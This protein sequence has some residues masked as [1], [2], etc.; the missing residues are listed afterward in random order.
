MKTV[1][2]DTST[3]AHL[4]ANQQ[5]SSA[6][7]SSDNFY[8]SDSTIWSY[9]THFPIAKHVINELGEYAVLFTTR[10]YSNTT[11]KHI[12]V[13]RQAC[14]HKNIIYCNNPENGHQS[15]I[16]DFIYRIELFASSLVGAR[17]PEIHIEKVNQV[18]EEAKSYLK[19]FQLEA[20]ELLQKAFDIIDKEKYIEYSKEKSVILQAEAEKRL[21]AQ[22]K[23][24]REELNKWLIGKTHRLYT[25]GKH[26][27]LR[28]LDGLIIETTQAVKI[29]TELGRELYNRIK[30]NKLVVG[31]HVLSYEVKEVGKEYKIGCHTFPRRYLLEWGKKHLVDN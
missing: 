27:Y 17:K 11:A 7:N 26:D 13:V 5:Q 18:I 2:T 6:R 14:R 8:F 31:S 4:W 20:P 25:Y 23:K 24:H 21:L 9:G 22:E 10:T 30:E 28:C 12:S 16:N 3:I 15:N 29:S 1:F 19:F